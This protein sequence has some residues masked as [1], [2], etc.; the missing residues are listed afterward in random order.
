MAISSVGFKSDWIEAGLVGKW[1][2]GSKI[3]FG[4]WI[5]HPKNFET[6]MIFIV[7]QILLFS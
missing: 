3:G 2:G 7:L 4:P 6:S 1:T 5:Y